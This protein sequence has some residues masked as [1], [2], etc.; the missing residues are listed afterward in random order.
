M[1]RSLD[2]ANRFVA[3]VDREAL[4]RK[5]RITRNLLARVLRLPE[6]EDAAEAGDAA[7]FGGKDPNMGETADHDG[8]M[9]D[10]RP[11]G[12]DDRPETET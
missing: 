12:A 11:E 9:S 10:K 6:F 7:D 8:E 5:E 4:A 2:A 3:A 1:E